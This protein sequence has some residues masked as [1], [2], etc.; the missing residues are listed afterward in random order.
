MF[1]FEMLGQIAEMILLGV[2]IL[3][4]GLLLTFLVGGITYVSAVRKYKK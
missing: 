2:A 1:A 3:G 4:G